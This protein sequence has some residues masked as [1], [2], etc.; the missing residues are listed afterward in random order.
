MRGATI[1]DSD[2]GDAEQCRRGMPERGSSLAYDG[3]TAWFLACKVIRIMRNILRFQS[4]VILILP[5]IK[6]NQTKD[7]YQPF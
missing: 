4:K 3:Y 7:H 2:F 6:Y 1:K 5:C